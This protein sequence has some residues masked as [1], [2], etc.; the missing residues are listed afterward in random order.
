LTGTGNKVVISGTDPSFF[1]IPTQPS[2]KIP[3]GGSADFDIV[4]TATAITGQK[5]TTIG[6]SS[7]DSDQSSLSFNA[8]G[9][10]LYS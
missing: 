5:N 6:I 2:Q 8:T 1:T 7:D 9:N 3:A 4:F 10:D